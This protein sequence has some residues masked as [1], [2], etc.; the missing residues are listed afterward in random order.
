[1]K[2]KNAAFLLLFFLSFSSFRQVQNMDEWVYEREKKGIKVFTKK[3]KWGHLRDSK[4]T[5]QVSATPEEVVK[6]LSDFDNYPNW[7]PRCKKAQVVAKLNDNEFIAYLVFNAPWPV[8]DRDCV[9]RVK[10]ERDKQTGIITITQTSE[11]KCVARK[12]DCF[13][14]DQIIS[15]WKMV[16]KNGGTEITNEYASNPGGNIPDWLINTQSVDNPMVTFESLQGKVVTK[17]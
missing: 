17:K 5:M 15:T 12:E 1:M 3:S 4:A 6:Y 16:P 11:P 2:Q 7:F 13:R 10:T 9:L 8:A 14:I